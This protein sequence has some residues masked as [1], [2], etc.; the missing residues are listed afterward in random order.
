MCTGDTAQPS[1][2]LFTA[3]D[4][5]PAAS[6]VAGTVRALPGVCRA[7]LN[8]VET[9]D[10]AFGPYELIDI[11]SNAACEAE[12]GSCAPVRRAFEEALFSDDACMT[13]DETRYATWLNGPTCR[14]PD[15]IFAEGGNWYRAGPLVE[16]ELYALAAEC[17][18]AREQPWIKSIFAFGDGLSEEF[19]TLSSLEQGTGRLHAFFTGEESTALTADPPPDL[20]LLDTD[21]G[22]DCRVQMF[23]DGVLRC[24]PTLSI[25]SGFPDE[26]N[27]PD[28]TQPIRSCMSGNCVGSIV[29]DLGIDSA[30]CSTAQHVTGVW[31]IT[32]PATG[33]YRQDENLPCYE[34]GNVNPGQWIV[35]AVPTSDLGT[36]TLETA[37]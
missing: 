19:V 5:V 25:G 3:G 7:T 9:E 29:Y 17:L 10:G 6:F 30:S 31:R 33:F 11:A 23:D 35:E 2:N 1:A 28:C 8:V 12:G 27:D 20:V 16:T 37:D 13:P 14:P 24:V 15:F 36:L 26:Y 4:E 21:S 18:P 34:G 22:E 32:G